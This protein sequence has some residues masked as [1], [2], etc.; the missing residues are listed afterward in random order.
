MTTNYTVPQ[1]ADSIYWVGSRDWNRRI[2]DALVPLPQGTTYNSYVVQGNSKTAVIDTVNPG[3]EEEWA[4]KLGQITKI[5]DID[6]VIMN[7]AEPDHSGAIPYILARNSKAKLVLTEKGAGMAEVYYK[8]PRERMQVVGEGDSIDLGGKTL[9]FIDAPWL[10]WPETMFTY[11]PETKTLFPC[12]FFGAH[13]A[14]VLYS[15]EGMETFSAAK[16]YFGEIMMPFRKKGQDAMRKVEQLEIA[17]IAPSHG[18]I[19]DKPEV[20]MDAYRTWTAGE[21]R[22]KALLVYVSMWNSTEKMMKTLAET[23]MARNIEVILHNLVN[24]DIGEIAGDLVDAR[25]VVLGS[26]TV[27]GGLHPL[28]VYAAHLVKALRPPTQYAAVLSSYGWGKGAAKQAAEILEPTKMEILDA[29]EV[30]GPASK[31]DYFH[32]IEMGE[33]LAEKIMAG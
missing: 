33:K 26:P 8:V 3:F 25:A 1:I 16:R 32:V 2:F 24:A 27:L 20:I 12:D 23:L 11:V 15:G 28:A 19:H 13:T 6:Y 7:H 21:T 22:Q 5:G 14:F 10:H 29:F 4:A 30:R 31:A 18:P 9:R 17:L